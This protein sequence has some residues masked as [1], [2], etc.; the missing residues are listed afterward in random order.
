M[1][2]KNPSNSEGF[3]LA[4]VFHKENKRFRRLKDKMITG[5]LIFRHGPQKSE[6]YQ[7][8]KYSKLCAKYE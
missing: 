8:T 7:I 4:P 3:G 5:E 1:T 2:E 6:N